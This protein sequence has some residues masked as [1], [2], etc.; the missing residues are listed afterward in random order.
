MQ[1]LYPCNFTWRQAFN[2]P[3]FNF[4]TRPAL[5]SERHKQLCC[6][7]IILFSYPCRCVDTTTAIC[8]KHVH[9]HIQSRHK[10]T[11][12]RS[13]SRNTGSTACFCLKMPL[14]HMQSLLGSCF[15]LE[16]Q[17]LVFCIRNTPLHVLHYS[18]V[19]VGTILHCARQCVNLSPTTAAA[20]QM[21][22]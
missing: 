3:S 12:C 5:L 2:L 11:R 8:Q 1:L 6:G 22:G 10:S 19:L 14:W 21:C 7:D 17:I 13:G 16:S 20:L 4:S 9:I 18:P 15:S